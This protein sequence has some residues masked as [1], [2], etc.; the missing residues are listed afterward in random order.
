MSSTRLSRS[1]LL[2][3]GMAYKQFIEFHPQFSKTD[4]T[5]SSVKKN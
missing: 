5:P 2:L 4:T 1:H 3:L